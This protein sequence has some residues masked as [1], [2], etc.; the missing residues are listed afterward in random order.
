M[1]SYRIDAL[2]TIIRRI[3]IRGSLLHQ[4]AM[5]RKRTLQFIF[6]EIFELHSGLR[7]HF[8]FHGL[9]TGVAHIL[10]LHQIHHVLADI[11]GVVTDALQGAG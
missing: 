8:P 3:P 7:A 2:V 11:G 4:K 5:V 10:A 1:H 6:P 9:E